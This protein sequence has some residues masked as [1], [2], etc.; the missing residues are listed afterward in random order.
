M[1]LPDSASNQSTDSPLIDSNSDDAAIGSPADARVVAWK[2]LHDPRTS[3]ARLAEIATEHPE[4]AARIG[5]HPNA[6]P[7]LRAWANQAARFSAQPERTAADS[8]SDTGNQPQPSAS[9]SQARRSFS[10]RW[11]LWAMAGIVGAGVLA[12]IATVMIPH[13]S[14]PSTRSSPVTARQAQAIASSLIADA[15][16]VSAGEAKSE[17]AQGVAHSKPQRCVPLSDLGSAPIASS[18]DDFAGS[19]FRGDLKFGDHDWIALRAFPDAIS[20]KNY[21][22]A[23]ANAADACPRWSMGGGN[24]S[25]AGFSATRQEHG[26]W[27]ILQFSW[28]SDFANSR[29]S[30]GGPCF[31]LLRDNLAAILEPNASGG[32]DDSAL[33]RVISM[34]NRYFSP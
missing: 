24:A 12:I 7:E 20:A 32:I 3:A 27:D 25:F 9:E 5:A 33:S 1:G 30:G 17:F 2:A 29:D 26:A 31:V 13:L 8:A 11:R 28:K 15:H 16:D 22:D 23:F 34:L 18:S 10:R 14:D 19:A 21:F 4:F 6:Y